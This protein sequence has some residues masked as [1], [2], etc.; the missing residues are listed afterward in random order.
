MNCKVGN[1]RTVSLPEPRVEWLPDNRQMR[2]L[3]PYEFCFCRGPEHIHAYIPE[4]FEFDGA[5]IP[6]VAWATTGSPYVG[7]HRKPA[8]THD[9]SYVKGMLRRVD[10]GEEIILTRKEADAL[11]LSGCIFEGMGW[12]TRNKIW[13]AVR[14]AGWKYYRD[15]EG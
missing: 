7:N 1:I 6:R 3:E 12:Y 14:A 9:A 15:G 2:L 8:L 5:S 11:L 10:T 13:L 4:G